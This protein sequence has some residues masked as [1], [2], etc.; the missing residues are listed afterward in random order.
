MS[1]EPHNVRTVCI[2]SVMP[3]K[4]APKVLPVPALSMAEEARLVRERFNRQNGRYSFTEEPNRARQEEAKAKQD[5][6]IIQIT[7]ILR[8]KGPTV[9]VDLMMATGSASWPMR[10]A[11][12]RME[13]DGLAVRGRRTS[14]GWLWGL[15]E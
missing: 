11:L 14:S 15:V 6:L 9:P 13:R 7:D 10:H 1:I 8:K 12:I 3:P 2:G 5:T 4:T